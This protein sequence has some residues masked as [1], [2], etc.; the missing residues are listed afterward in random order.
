M[1][2]NAGGGEVRD[3]IFDNVLRTSANA[4]MYP[5]VA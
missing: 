1:K 5:H 3:D 2:E 4:T